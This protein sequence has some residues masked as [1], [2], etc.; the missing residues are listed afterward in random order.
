MKEVTQI[1]E[2][3]LHD[4]DVLMVGDDYKGSPI[5]MWQYDVL[6]GSKDIINRYKNAL[7]PRTFKG[8]KIKIQY[9]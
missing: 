1:A 4:K 8:H 6:I 3:H 2:Y 5:I 9:V 7:I